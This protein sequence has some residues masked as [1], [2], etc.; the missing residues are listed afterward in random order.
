M[1]RVIKRTFRA[2]KFARTIYPAET[3][4]TPRLELMTRRWLLRSGSFQFSMLLL[5]IR[6]TPHGVPGSRARLTVEKAKWT[7]F[8]FRPGEPVKSW[9]YIYDTRC[10]W[11]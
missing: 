1:Y 8:H 4:T 3:E 5:T 2:F 6:R 11:I 9:T 10:K 7:H